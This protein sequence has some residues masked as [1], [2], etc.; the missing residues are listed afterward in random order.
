[1]LC[2]H[3]STDLTFTMGQR[4]DPQGIESFIDN[5]IRWSAL[6]KI[7]GQSWKLND[8]ANAHPELAEAVKVFSLW[9][10]VGILCMTVE[11]LAVG[12]NGV[13]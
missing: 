13:I 11:S 8:P 9:V 5:A 2:L 3:F 12:R 10:C 4:Q 7:V 6:S 1:M